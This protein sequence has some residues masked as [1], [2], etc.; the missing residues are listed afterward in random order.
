MLA[1]NN[2]TFV[3]ERELN[4]P[5]NSLAVNRGYGAYEFFEVIKGQPFYMERHLARFKQTLQLLHLSIDYLDNLE[6][7]VFELLAKNEVKN[8]FV[9]L[10]AFPE[11]NAQSKS[12]SGLYAYLIDFSRFTPEQYSQG[13]KLIMR[14]YKR[15]L[16]E[17]KSTNYLASEYYKP[18]IDAIQAADVLFYDNNQLRE[19]SRGNVFIVS[20]GKVFTPKEDMLF[21]VTRSIVLDLMIEEKIPVEIVDVSLEMLKHADEV[22]ITSTTKQIM[23]IIQ[24]DDQKLGNAKPGVLTKRIMELFFEHKKFFF[25][26]SSNWVIT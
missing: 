3:D 2:G 11:S 13:F 22:F 21:G 1:F 16:P 7:I 17:A 5:L 10:F 26:H 23:P 25:G 9:K 12:N 20:G 18:E 15:F 24:I 14:P 4:Q 19:T 8:T 6:S